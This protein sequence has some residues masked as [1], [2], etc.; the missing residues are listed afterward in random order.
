MSETSPNTHRSNGDGDRAAA[1]VANQE[2]RPEHHEEVIPKDLPQVKAG[3][4]I[5]ASLALV[6]VLVALF[7]IGY[8]PQRNRESKLRAEAS[9]VQDAK[10]IVTIAPAKRQ[11]QS[12]D[13]VLPG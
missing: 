7:L 3:T 2:H 10:P 4:I 8:I 12:T 9:Q 5:L 11:A 6:C 13:L 1:A